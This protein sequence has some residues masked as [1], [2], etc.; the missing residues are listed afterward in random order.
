MDR[1]LGTVMRSD[2]RY[3]TGLSAT[4]QGA[5]IPYGYTLSVWCTGEILTSLRGTP[6]PGLAI[7][8]VAGAAAAFLV[9]RW[10]AR[11]TQPDITPAGG[12]E[13]N[14]LAVA[15]AIQVAAIGAV[16]GCVTLL[17]QFLRSGL[18]WP[19]AGFVLT[20]VYLCGTAAGVA[21]RG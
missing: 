8:F 21:L 17:G 1:S 2:G 7:A 11:E 10:A 15:I 16:I 4:L 20:A 19:L 6:S 9:L 3:A 12:N 14:G 18:D 13:T 5:S